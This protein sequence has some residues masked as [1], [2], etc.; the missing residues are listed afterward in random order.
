MRQQPHWIQSPT[1]VVTSS[2]VYVIFVSLAKLFVKQKP[3]GQKDP[4]LLKLIVLIHNVFLVALS[5]YMSGGMVYQ[6][7]K[8][9]YK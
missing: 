4:A 6:I 3:K 8:N 9:N 1:V 7:Y 2:L 5:A